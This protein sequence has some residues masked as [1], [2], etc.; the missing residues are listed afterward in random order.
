[1]IEQYL[2]EAVLMVFVAGFTWGFR[3][4]AAAQK[5]ATETII[6]RLETVYISL[7]NHRLESTEGFARLDERVKTLERPAPM[8]LSSIGQTPV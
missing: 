4:W 2:S 1:M 3:T 8:Q 5:K 6:E 7:H